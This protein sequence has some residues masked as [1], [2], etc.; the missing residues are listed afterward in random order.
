[1]SS[2]WA[3]DAGTA[4]KSNSRVAST[5]TESADRDLIPVGEKQARFTVWQRQRPQTPGNLQE[6]PPGAVVRS[7]YRAAGNQIAGPQ[8][9]AVAR[10]MRHHLSHRPIHVAERAATEAHGLQP[11][12]PHALRLKAHVDGQIHAADSFV[13]RMREIRQEGRVLRPAR[14]PR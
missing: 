12:F 14:T 9:A 1:M 2:C 7:R 11:L 10:M 8:V 5:L 4:A 13:A 6:A 3:H